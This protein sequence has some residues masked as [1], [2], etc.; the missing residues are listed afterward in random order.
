MNAQ[1]TDERVKAYKAEGATA[2][3]EALA[4][5]SLAGTFWHRAAGRATAGKLA[6]D[7]ERSGVALVGKQVHDQHQ[8][9]DELLA[10]RGVQPSE[11]HQPLFDMIG[12]SRRRARRPPSVLRGRRWVTHH[13][14]D[15]WRGLRRWMASKYACG[16]WAGRGCAST[17]GGEPGGG[18]GSPLRFTCDTQFLRE[19]IRF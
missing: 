6:G 13:N 18:G 15:M 7:L 8:H 1:P 9:G 5:S 3:L 11:C 4:F 19:S 16:R 10:G 14:I 12:T 17:S 2:N